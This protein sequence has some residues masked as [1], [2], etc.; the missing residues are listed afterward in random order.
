[1]AKLHALLQPYVPISSDHFD[2]VKAAHLLNRAGFGGKPEEVE[3][4]LEL[5]P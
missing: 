5:G 2:P 1:M 4:V 3:A